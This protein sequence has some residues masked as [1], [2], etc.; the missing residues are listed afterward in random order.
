MARPHR[1]EKVAEDIVYL[2]CG[3]AGKSLAGAQG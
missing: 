3:C 2:E 1:H